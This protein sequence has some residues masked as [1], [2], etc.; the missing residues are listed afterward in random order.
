MGALSAMSYRSDLSSVV[1]PP[2][3]FLHADTLIGAKV[4]VSERVADTPAH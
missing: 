1:R 3:E 4:R 2:F